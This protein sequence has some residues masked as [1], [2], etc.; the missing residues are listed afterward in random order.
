M[1]K[2]RNEPVKVKKSVENFEFSDITQNSTNFSDINVGA[3][4][5]ETQPFLFN[6]INPDE[7]KKFDLKELNKLV[8]ASAL[9]MVSKLFSYGGI[10]KKLLHN[11]LDG[12]VNVFN[13]N[14]LNFISETF[15]D[16]HLNDMLNMIRD[17]F[18]LFRSI[19]STENFLKDLNLNLR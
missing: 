14:C 5:S 8:Q 2:K 18:E 16:N 12:F 1:I 19:H 17:G 6:F 9:L 4:I 11:I 3:N 7:K 13:L 10:N 15:P